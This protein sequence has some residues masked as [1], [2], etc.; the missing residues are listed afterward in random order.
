[1]NRLFQTVQRSFGPV[2]GIFVLAA[3]TSGGL[4]AQDC[5]RACLTNMITKY[6]A[7][8]AAHDASRLPLAANVRFTEDSR[9]LKPGEGLWK[10]VV[11][12]G[13]FRQDYIDLKDQIAAA[14]VNMFEADG[15]VL[16]SVLLRVADQKITGIETQVYR[17]KEQPTFKPP[18]SLGKPLVGMGVPVPEG[19]RMNRDQ[20]IRIALTYTEGLRIGSFTK[21][22]TPFG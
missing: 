8:L 16:H 2:T 9:D 18:E 19:Q 1:M 4:E 21:S 5:N 12:M 15:Q 14:H 6:L 10:T 3:M 13:T 17:V 22:N 20:M 11:R 7:A